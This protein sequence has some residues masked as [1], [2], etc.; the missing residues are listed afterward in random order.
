MLLPRVSLLARIIDS[1]HNGTS[2]PELYK[3]D[4]MKYWVE[5]IRAEADLFESRHQVGDGAD[6]SCYCDAWLVC[7]A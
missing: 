2:V 3:P 5:Q 6:M 1:L 4:Q 7:I